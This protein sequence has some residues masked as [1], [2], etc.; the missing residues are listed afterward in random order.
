MPSR[1]L[2]RFRPA[3][4]AETALDV[5]ITVI[6]LVATATLIGR[7]TTV[8]RKG[9][10]NT[11]PPMPR[12]A[13]KP[14]ARI[15]EIMTDAITRGVMMSGSSVMKS[16]LMFERFFDAGL[17]QAA[18]LIACPRTREAVVIDPRRD[19]DAIVAMARQHRLSLAYAIE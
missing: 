11:P 10:R 9:T 15:P 17:A 12:S 16:Y 8:L 5:P 18:Y 7:P 14:P 3:V 2:I 13:A 4:L 6:K 19:I 1:R